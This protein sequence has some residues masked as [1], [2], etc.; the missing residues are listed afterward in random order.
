MIAAM[1]FYDCDSHSFHFMD[2]RPMKGDGFMTFAKDFAQGRLELY[3]KMRKNA[4]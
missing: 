2:S 4:S 3:E 1:S